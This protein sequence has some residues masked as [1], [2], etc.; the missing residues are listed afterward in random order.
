MRA[1]RS[2]GRGPC[3]S[4]SRTVAPSS[5]SRTRNASPLSVP[6]SRSRTRF[7]CW[8]RASVRASAAKRRSCWT[9]RITLT[10]TSRSSRTSRARYT[11]AIPPR[12]IRPSM[13]YR[14]WR[15]V[16]VPIMWG[17]SGACRR[18]AFLPPW[19]PGA[20]VRLRARCSTSTGRWPGMSEPVAHR[21]HGLDEPGPLLA[22][23]GPQPADVH[24]DR[25]GSSV[26]LITPHA[27]QELLAGEH[28]ARVRREEPQQLVLHVGEVEGAVG[29]RGLVRLEVEHEIAV[30]HNFGA[31]RSPGPPS[32][33]TQTRLEFPRMERREAE[34][35]ER[36]LPHLQLGEL[37]SGD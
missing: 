18:S 35:V 34:V 16:S 9:S 5:S 6:A 4:S 29:H 30:L 21:P 1:T 28:L 20:S 7:G 15:R 27:G 36:V 26:V 33:V 14:L 24:V 19:T 8:S 13:R 23:L 31:R 17:P 32:Q 3:S 22:E 11:S 2:G 10:A 37:R 12:S 25:P